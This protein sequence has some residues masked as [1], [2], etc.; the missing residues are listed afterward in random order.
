MTGLQALQIR[1]RDGRAG[2]TQQGASWGKG[3]REKVVTGTP[4]LLFFLFL[5]P[6]PIVFPCGYS[7]EY[8]IRLSL[9]WPAQPKSGTTRKCVNYCCK[10]DFHICP[11]LKFGWTCAPFLT[12]PWLELLFCHHENPDSQNASSCPLSTKSNLLA[13]ETL[14]EMCF[15]W[16]LATCPFTTW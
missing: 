14:T 6:L 3:G 5:L 1:V 15:C 12:A 2:M 16:A 13:P 11:D 7:H 8:V 4:R 10:L 9:R